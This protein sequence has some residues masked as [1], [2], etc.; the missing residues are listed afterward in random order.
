MSTQ[1]PR[2]PIYDDLALIRNPPQPSTNKTNTTPTPT[3]RLAAQVRQGRLLLHSYVSRGE[4][5]ANAFM[6]TLL[7]HEHSFTSTMASLAPPR[8]S[9]ERLLPASI[10]VLVATMA[11]SIISRNRNILIRATFPA[12]VGIGTAWTVLPITMQNVSD[13]AWEYEERSPFVKENHL[14]VRA[15]VI[16]AV[17]ASKEQSEGLRKGIDEGM[18]RGR[19]TVED[20]VRKGR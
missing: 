20:F 1:V 6:S 11:G 17:K 9:K 16:A 14:R 4:D 2:K 7:Q 3:D 15:A 5:S 13:L 12:A 18:R 10:Y 8:D 19:Q